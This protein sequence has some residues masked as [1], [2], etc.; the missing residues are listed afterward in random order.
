[1]VQVAEYQCASSSTCHT[2]CW[3][4]LVVVLYQYYNRG[5]YS[6]WKC[7]EKFIHRETQWRKCHYLAWNECK[8][9]FNKQLVRYL[10]HDWLNS[11]ELFANSEILEGCRFYLLTKYRMLLFWSISFFKYSSQCTIFLYRSPQAAAEAIGLPDELV[12]YFALFLLKETKN[13]GAESKF[14][15]QF[16]E[17]QRLRCTM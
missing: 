1:M 15:I 2:V 12:Y 10:L 14:L 11:W 17:K 9:N 13:N 5:P 16:E 6:M 8:T 4:L 7:S 3:I